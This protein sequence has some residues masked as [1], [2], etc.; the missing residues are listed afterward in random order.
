MYESYYL[1]LHNDRDN[2][3]IIENDSFL[4]LISELFNDLQHNL[5]DLIVY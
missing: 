2:E 4:F 5:I 1:V 3:I